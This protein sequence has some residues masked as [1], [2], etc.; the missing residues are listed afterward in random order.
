VLDTTLIKLLVYQG[1]VLLIIRKKQTNKK[2]WYEIIRVIFDV[3]EI[4]KLHLLYFYFMMI[5]KSNFV[6]SWFYISITNYC[7][8]KVFKY[9]YNII[10]CMRNT[11]LASILLVSLFCLLLYV[12]SLHNC[13]QVSLFKPLYFDILKRHKYA[14]FIFNE[15][16]LLFFP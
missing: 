6:L 10:Y 13:F 7:S 16:L 8:H 4:W 1:C 14:I 9:K 11:E 2:P 15:C 5:K 12:L 3:T